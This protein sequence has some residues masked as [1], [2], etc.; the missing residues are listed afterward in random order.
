MGIAKSLRKADHLSGLGQG[1]SEIASILEANRKKKEQEQLYSTLLDY[2]NKWQQGLKEA[3]MPVNLKE[4]G[5][6]NNV[7][8]PEN[9]TSPI[10]GQKPTGMN[11]RIPDNVQQIQE[12]MLPVA[13]QTQTRK[14]PAAEQH[15]LAQ[16]NLS[17]FVTSLAS[18][19]LNQ[20]AD[21]KLLSKVNV[22]SGLAQQETE[23]TKPKVGTVFERDPFKKYVERDDYGNEKTIQEADSKQKPFDIEGSYKNSKTKTYWSYDKQTGKHFDT[24]IPYDPNEGRATVN[25]KTG[26]DEVKKLG[27][28]ASELVANLRNIDPYVKD[29]EGNYIKDDKGN[30]VRKTPED[31]KYEQDKTLEKMKLQLL[32]GKTYHYLNNLELLEGS[33]LSPQQIKEAAERD[34][35]NDEIGDEELKELKNYLYYY[36]ENIYEGLAK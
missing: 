18:L 15:K 29:K 6:V 8:S 22:L 16:E 24:G 20:N 33:Y 2:Y 11:L 28:N 12:N 30:K 26:K 13:P 34:Y 31:L 17:D 36:T 23:R 3:K 5:Q 25:I 27:D 14:V 7:F 21:D 4:G 32:S 9:F 10:S 35:L 19:L 1:L